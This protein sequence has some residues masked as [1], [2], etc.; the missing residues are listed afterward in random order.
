MS[1]KIFIAQYRNEWFDQLNTFLL[2]L[3]YKTRWDASIA[4]T[5]TS[6]DLCFKLFELNDNGFCWDSN[7][8][9]MDGVGKLKM[10]KTYS[11]NSYTASCM[12]FIS[13]Y[14]CFYV[15]D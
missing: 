1:F 12:A 15:I 2:H 3:V 6:I 13:V 11:R 5:T 4:S 10:F 9:S 14:T 7:H 8:H